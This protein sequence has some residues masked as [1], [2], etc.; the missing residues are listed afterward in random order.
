MLILGLLGMYFDAAVVFFTMAS[1]FF[2]MAMT[3]LCYAKD[4]CKSCI[5]LHYYTSHS[6]AI[7]ILNKSEEI[8]K[9]TME[10]SKYIC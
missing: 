7:A 4:I 8:V 1:L 2:R 5:A 3:L 10:A 6:T 9:N